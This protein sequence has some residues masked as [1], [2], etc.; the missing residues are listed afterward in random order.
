M[1]LTEFKTLIQN[2]VENSETTFTNTLND[3][4]KTTEERIFELGN[5]IIKIYGNSNFLLDERKIYLHYEMIPEIII[6]K[7]IIP[8][9]KYLTFKYKLTSCMSC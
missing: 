5:E 9:W 4:I 8:L 7:Y 3:I 6:T 1:T 2:Y